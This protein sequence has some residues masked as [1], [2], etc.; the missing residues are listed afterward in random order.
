MLPSLSPAQLILV[1]DGYV[2]AVMF[3]VKDT[4]WVNVIDEVIVQ[5]FTSVAVTVY[6]PAGN[7]LMSSFVDPVLHWYV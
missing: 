1:P 3:C 7:P 5:P 4:G 2:N 6:V